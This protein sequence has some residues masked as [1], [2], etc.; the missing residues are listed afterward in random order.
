[1]LLFGTRYE[2]NKQD[3]WIHFFLHALQ[4]TNSRH[5]RTSEGILPSVY[6]SSP[7]SGIFLAKLS[8]NRSAVLAL[9]SRGYPKSTA[10]LHNDNKSLFGKAKRRRTCELYSP[11]R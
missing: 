4:P 5:E 9:F 1:M 3:R 8:T 2:I 6:P 11:R 7:P 10:F